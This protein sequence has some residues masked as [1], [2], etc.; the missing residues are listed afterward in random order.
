MSSCTYSPSLNKR[1]DQ[2]IVYRE[3]DRWI[4]NTVSQ[5]ADRT[6]FK[7]R[8][9]SEPI[10]SAQASTVPFGEESVT[11]LLHKFIFLGDDRNIVKVVVAGRVLKGL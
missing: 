9:A 11:D 1:L 3:K 7:R 2:L 6:L 4:D 5:S 10:F 8:S